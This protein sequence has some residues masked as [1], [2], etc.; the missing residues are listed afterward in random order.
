MLKKIRTTKLSML[1]LFLLIPGIAL[2]LIVF[3]CQ[4]NAE[5]SQGGQ[6]NPASILDQNGKAQKPPDVSKKAPKASSEVMPEY[7]G[8]SAKM[9]E[10]LAK[11]IKYPE[12]G[13]KDNVTGVVYTSF[14]ID[15]KGKVTD[16]KVDKGINSD[17][18]NEAM[19]VIKMMPDWTPG[20][21]DGKINK[22]K[23]TV[24]ISFKLK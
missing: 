19:R 3:S 14:V 20:K 5:S 4:K 23:L 21:T 17:F 22:I 2:M 15:E 9:I 6:N 11:N 10:F 7:P 1:K 18:D 8:G 16:V 13:K 24:P 12:S